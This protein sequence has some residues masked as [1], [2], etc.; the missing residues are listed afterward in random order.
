MHLLGD[1][2]SPF[3]IGVFNEELGMEVGMTVTFVWLYFGALAWYLAY[4]TGRF[5]GKFTFC[6]ATMNI[7]TPTPSESLFLLKTNFNMTN[8]ISMEDHGSL[9]SEEDDYS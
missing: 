9:I 4:N 1:F 6:Q 5:L 3:L 7:C 2:P 8:S